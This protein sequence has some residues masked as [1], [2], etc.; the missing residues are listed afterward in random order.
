MVPRQL[1]FS[2]YPYAMSSQR[3][4]HNTGREQSLDRVRV[5]A[6]DHTANLIWRE[7]RPQGRRDRHGRGLRG[8]LLFPALPAWKTRREQFHQEVELALGDLVAK[9][10]QVASIEFGVQDVPPS[11][12]ADWEDHDVVLARVF[13]RDRRRGLSDRIVLYR[14]PLAGRTTPQTLPG[15]IR[16]VLAHKISEVLAVSPADLLDY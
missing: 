12:P 15:A 9:E 10:P 16:L 13:P 6:C 11:D 2:R 8:P 3:A 4:P 7:P 14:R 1:G 5:A